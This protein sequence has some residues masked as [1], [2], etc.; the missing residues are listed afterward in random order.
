MDYGEVSSLLARTAGGFNALLHTGSAAQGAPMRLQTAPGIFDLS[1]R[2][3]LIF[4]LKCLDEKIAPSL[5][6]V[7]RLVNEADF[8]DHR[9][10]NDLVLEMKNELDSSLAP[11]GHVYASGRASCFNSRSKKVEETWNGL[12]QID[13]VHRLAKM[14]TAEIAA[15]MEYLR[16]KISSAGLI[17]NITGCALD[18]AG[19]ELAKRFSRFGAPKDRS[20]AF[21]EAT[22]ELQSSPAVS[23]IYASPSMQIGFAALSLNAA[24]FDTKEQ[25]AEMVL[26]HQLSTG[27]LWEDIRMKGGAYGAFVNSD[28]LENSV[29]F[30]TYR[31]P[32]P[33]RSLDVISAILKNGSPGDC[34]EDYLVKS[35]IGCYAKETRPRTSSE[36][37]L[38]DFYRFLYGIEDSY[39]KRKLERLVSVSTGDIAAAF[40]ALG[41]RKARPPVI[42]TG[43]KS[44]E[45]A[46][47][48]LGVQ[49]RRLPV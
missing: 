24:P 40:T 47:K 20:A 48:K 10:I 37:G 49:V 27:A 11:M 17:A 14:E 13:F 39:R 9:R 44:A 15:K 19:A 22:Q 34:D 6:L 16:G 31:D 8:S 21:N 4:R 35:I 46:A 45:Q 2:D 30:A 41:S 33:L 26:A 36:N 12:S 43:E 5:D 1:G 28:S 25:L 29:S 3:W 23:E 7:L 42:I 32:N 18:T 38:I